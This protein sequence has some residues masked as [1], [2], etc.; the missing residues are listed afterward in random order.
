VSAQTALAMVIHYVKT[1]GFGLH[2]REARG[3]Y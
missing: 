2:C 1:F 3:D